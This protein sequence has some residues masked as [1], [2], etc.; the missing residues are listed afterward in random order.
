MTMVKRTHIENSSC[1]QCR[2]NGNTK[3]PDR[4]VVNLE[5]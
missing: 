5:Q 3:E 1:Q 2:E 4:T